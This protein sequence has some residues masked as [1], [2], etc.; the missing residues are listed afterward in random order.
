MTAQC[1]PVVTNCCQTHFDG[2]KVDDNDDDNNDDGDDDDIQIKHHLFFIQ[3]PFQTEQ[4]LGIN[5]SVM[6]LIFLHSQ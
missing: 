5:D 1:H 4:S 3:C 2:R 6:M